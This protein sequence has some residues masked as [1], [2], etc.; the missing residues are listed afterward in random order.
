MKGRIHVAGARKDA[1]TDAELTNVFLFKGGMEIDRTLTDR[2]GAFNFDSIA[3]GNY[4]LM[5]IGPDGIALIGF[6]LVDA[7]AFAGTAASNVA[8]D[9]TQLVGFGRLFGGGHQN[10]C[11]CEE[12]AI[13]VA[14]CPEV[15][16]C[17]EEVICEVVIS[18]T[19]VEDGCCGGIPGE[20][21]EGEVVMDGFGTPL[22]GGGYGSGGGGGGFGGGGGSG[23][24][25]GGIGA[26][27]GL[28]GIGAI[29]AATS[30]ND[31]N[32]AIVAPI[33]ASPS[34]PN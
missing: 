25:F 24:G 22:A 33:V 7:A 6:E 26:L 32:N 1:L 12:F 27:A 19:I 14:P 30:D 28:A 3:V 17:V 21:I 4:S 31:D 9:G 34:L 23:G 2:N 15:V 13:Q 16:T 11:C 8:G 29:I 10:Q 18:E 20:I 5:A